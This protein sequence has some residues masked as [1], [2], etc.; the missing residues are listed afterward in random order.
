MFGQL[1]SVLK[2][3]E[4]L[5][6]SEVRNWPIL[7]TSRWAVNEPVSSFSGHCMFPR[8]RQLANVVPFP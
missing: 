6:L 8:D 7:G 1:G 4:L 3:S 5:D 2:V